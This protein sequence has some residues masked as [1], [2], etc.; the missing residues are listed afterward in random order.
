MSPDITPQKRAAAIIK[1]WLTPTMHARGFTKKGRIYTRILADV[2]HLMDIQQSESNK[3]TEVS[4]SLNIGVYVPGVRTTA[5]HGVM[6]AT[7]IGASGIVNTR[8]GLVAEP[9][10]DYWWE[11][12]SSDDQEKDD[13]IGQHMLSV[14]EGGAFRRFFDRFVDKK[15]LAEF[16]MLPRENSDQQIA[17]YVKSRDFV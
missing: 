10:K 3:K 6:P 14:V 13:D 11:V 7:L 15:S 5:H 9:K 8:A 2:V 1:K 17:P 12:K 16:L 4:F